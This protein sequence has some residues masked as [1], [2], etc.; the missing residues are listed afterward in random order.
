[1]ETLKIFLVFIIVNVLIVI[2]GLTSCVNKMLLLVW[3]IFVPTIEVNKV[4][5]VL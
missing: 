5:N 1:M 4:Q 3:I 2:V